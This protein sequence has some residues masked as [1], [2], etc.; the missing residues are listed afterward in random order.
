MIVMKAPAYRPGGA[1]TVRVNEDQA[2]ILRTVGWTDVIVER[3]EVEPSAQT[4]AETVEHIGIEP[5]AV[6]NR[7]VFPNESPYLQQT[8]YKISDLKARTKRKYT[9]RAIAIFD[10]EGNPVTVT[11]PKRRY[12]RRDMQAEDE[13]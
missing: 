6:E 7:A 11:K 3:V 10:D 9:R 5:S 1:R 8:N 4:V 2:R 12:R 13:K